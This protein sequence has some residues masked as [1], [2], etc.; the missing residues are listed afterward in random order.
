[1]KHCGVGR[2]YPRNLA[3]KIPFRFQLLDIVPR[4]NPL[5]GYPSQSFYL[6]GKDEKGVPKCVEVRGFM[7]SVIVRQPSRVRPKAFQC[8]LKDAFIEVKMAPHRRLLEPYM[9][10]KKFLDSQRYASSSRYDVLKCRKRDNGD[11]I[12]I[13]EIKELYVERQLDALRARKDTAL[14]FRAIEGRD[15]CDVSAS[16]ILNGG[17]DCFYKIQVE[18]WTDFY[19][20]KKAL[21]LPHFYKEFYDCEPRLYN[22]NVSL[23][24]RW[25][26]EF[27]IK[28]CFW[29]SG[30][31]TNCA[32]AALN[33]PYRDAEVR[34]DAVKC[35]EVDTVCP[36]IIL[37]LDIETE[38]LETN[39]AERRAAAAAGEVVRPKVIFR[40]IGE[41]NILQI[42][43]VWVNTSD[44]SRVHQCLL[45]ITPEPSKGM[46]SE[47][48]EEHFKPSTASLMPCID[49]K[50]LLE[51]LRD[52]VL[53]I[54][55]DIITGYNVAAFDLN[56]IWKRCEK[57]NVTTH[58]SRFEGYECPM[59]VTKTSSRAHGSSE[60]YKFAIAGRTI[61]DLYDLMK[62]E[63][64]LIS[65]KLD[66]VAE[67]FL[68]T[69]KLD[70]KY[71]DIP[72]LQETEQGR[73][74]M[75]AYC[76]KDS[77]LV[78][79]LLEKLC[80]LSNV[81]EMA[82]VTG[83]SMRDVLDRGQMIR[84]LCSIYQYAQQHDPQYFLPEM[85]RK[86]RWRVTKRNTLT[87]AGSLK[88]EEKME[89]V[90]LK[91]YKGAVVFP[92][93]PGFYK[94]P[95]TCLDFASLYPSIMRYRN[96]CYSTLVSHATIK[97]LNLVEDVDYH[98][99]ADADIV[100]D[101]ELKITKHDDDTCFL[102]H[103]KRPGVL[104]AILASLLG[105]RK[106]AKRDMKT[107]KDVNM[108]NVCNGRQ[109]ALKLVCNSMY[110]FTGTSYGYL[111]CLH[112]ASAVT[113][114]G[115]FLALSTKAIVEKNFPGCQCVYG[116]TD[117]VFVKVPK[118]LLNVKDNAGIVRAVAELSEKMAKLCDKSYHLN[119]RGYINLEFEKVL[120]PL[121]LLKKKRYYSYKYE[122]GKLDKPAIDYKGIE[123]KRRDGSQITKTW[124]KAILSMVL[125]EQDLEKVKAYISNG[126]LDLYN[127]K[128]PVEEFIMSQKLTRAPSSYKVPGA[129]VKLAIKQMKDPSSS[130]R[131][132][133]RIPYCIR[134]G[135]KGEKSSDRAVDPAD[136]RSGK[137][138]VDLDHYIQKCIRK[139]L[140][141]MLKLVIPDI[142][143]LFCISER[144]HSS[145]RAMKRLFPGAV[146]QSR[147]RVK[148][149]TQR[150]SYPVVENSSD[151]VIKS[152]KQG[153][154]LSS[155][156][157]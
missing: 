11:V 100:G 78:I 42:S 2:S 9:T 140:V 134:A 56:V 62:K 23:V 6:Y 37:C 8:T 47:Y 14:R 139:P 5:S 117:S 25:M 58:W 44:M 35:E 48:D 89:E 129:H 10:I 87:N 94:D 77:W 31:G 84:S 33:M 155:Y 106:R 46:S 76:L 7:N 45:Y 152:E 57:F 61:L 101:G 73:L 3:V 49:E 104:P 128:V 90:E 50:Q 79:K 98:R 112:I 70:C 21:R 120:F 38:P 81:I 137:Y 132:G 74:K 17:S 12:P 80:K 153:V 127:K 157:K 69:K 115:R 72:T 144:K 130:V 114:T 103:K 65:Y 96:M 51:T 133:D 118:S 34:Y 40:G 99:I 88:T 20:L 136:I 68:G 131:V 26:L 28:P 54:N 154:S 66:V 43:L 110:G 125:I 148:R 15:I 123:C 146:I 138:A 22:C 18:R 85:V 107:A 119:Q 156:F 1:M 111:P 147:K 105:A 4:Q 53:K 108:Y 41:D 63:H 75:G 83:I 150:K 143:S 145:S 52:Q 39:K 97:E 30:S 124:Q 135:Y 60:N 93:T 32:S 13:K 91:G 59:K 19:A 149:R 86:P 116:D 64:S 95:V 71:E 36:M 55:P 121:V 102:T 82:R 126:L 109:L 113:A 141:S 92:P 67:K 29:I 16:S 122:E 27:S 142:E 24:Q 151:K